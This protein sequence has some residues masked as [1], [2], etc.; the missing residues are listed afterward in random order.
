MAFR[1]ALESG[2]TTVGVLPGS[3]NPVGGL[4]AAL[5]CYGKHKYEMLIKEPIGLKVAFGENPKRVHGLENRG[6]RQLEWQLQDW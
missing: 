6:P 1:E 4:G 3:T 2:V 5:K